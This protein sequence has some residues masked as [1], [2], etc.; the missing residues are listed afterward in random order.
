MAITWKWHGCH[1]KK[2]GGLNQALDDDDSLHSD[3][4]EQGWAGLEVS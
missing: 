1:F 3:F 2:S 4:R